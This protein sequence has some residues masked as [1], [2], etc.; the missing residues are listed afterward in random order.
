MNGSYEDQYRR[1]RLQLERCKVNYSVD[2]HPKLPF[3]MDKETVFST[4]MDFM[5]LFQDIFHLRDWLI[6]DPDVSISRNEMNQFFKKSP[7]MLLLQSVANAT[8]RL[9]LEPGQPDPY[10]DMRAIAI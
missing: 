5:H 10:V 8:K 7:N 1:T 2:G 3:T 9:I 6:N 4:V